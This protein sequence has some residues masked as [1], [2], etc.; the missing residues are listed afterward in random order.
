MTQLVFIHGPGAGGCAAAFRYQ[1]GH[2]PGS[3]APTLPGHLAGAPCES[4]ERYADWLRGWLWAQGQRRDLVL[5]GFTLGA[6]I[7]LQYALDYPDEVQG[8]VLMTVAMRPKSRE[9]A[10]Y[11]FRL[12][13]AEEPAVYEQ[14]IA[15]M[16]EA[17]RF[18]EPELREQLI[19]CHRQ[20]GPRSQHHDLVV[21]D[22]FDVRDRIRSLTP[23]L[24]LIRGVD[25]PLSPEDYEREIHEAIPGS[26]YIAL[27]EAGHFPMAEQPAAVN[28]AIQAFLDAL[29]ASQRRSA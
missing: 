29:Q 9:A 21:I 3:I 24:L 19:A 6:C 17:M 10:T 12:R 20:V 16:R 27:R 11:G 25:D 4:V 1:L 8:L 14:W 28:R 5:V 26:Q 15:A 22:R 13:A 18:V 23:P 7:A 2:F